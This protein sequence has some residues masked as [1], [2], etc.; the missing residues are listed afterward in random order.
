[1]GGPVAKVVKAAHRRALRRTFCHLRLTLGAWS[2]RLWMYAA[3]NTLAAGSGD[4]AASIASYNSRKALRSLGLA[5]ARKPSQM[6]LAASSKASGGRCG[7]GFGCDD[8]APIHAFK[9]EQGPK[10]TGYSFVK[11]AAFHRGEGSKLCNY[12]DTNQSAGSSAP[13]FTPR[14]RDVLI[15]AVRSGV[16]HLYDRV[17]G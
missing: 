4:G 16:P 9:R 5:S 11:N 13:Q 8:I 7:F 12:R 1:M 15:G 14:S 3:L 10:K 17:A 2:N 6:M